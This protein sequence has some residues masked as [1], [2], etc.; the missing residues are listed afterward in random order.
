MKRNA[1]NGG[2]A[3]VALLVFAMVIAGA[4]LIGRAVEVQQQND[5]TK[6]SIEKMDQRMQEQLKEELGSAGKVQTSGSGVSAVTNDTN[7]TGSVSGST[8]T[9]G[10]TGT[11]ADGRITSATTWNA[12]ADTASPTF[13]GK[14][15]QAYA[16]STGQSSQYASS[17][18]LFAGTASTSALTVSGVS[19]AQSVTT[20]LQI[21]TTGVVSSTGAAC[22]AAGS[23]PV[24]LLLDGTNYSTA[25]TSTTTLRTYTMPAGTLGANDALEI[26]AFTKDT[27]NLG[28]CQIDFGTGSAT[29]SL[30]SDSTG[31][32]SGWGMLTLR[33]HN[34][35]SVSSQRTFGV[36]FDDQ[37][38]TSEGRYGFDITVNTAATTYIAFSCRAFVASTINISGLRVTQYK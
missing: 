13:T 23:G 7:V 20:C 11:L 31:L 30:I 28:G 3:S 4:A 22:A 12:K 32:G 19:Q 8:L 18:N 21:A 15:T 10:W 34:Q 33:I 27:T 38:N 5:E 6:A 26:S 35:N 25:N 16:S 37:A 1:L 17:T 29:S 14:V 9:L 2:Y 36:S 24:D